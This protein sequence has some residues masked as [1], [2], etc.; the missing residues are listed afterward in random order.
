MIEV[1]PDNFEQLLDDG[2]L[3]AAMTSGKWSKMRRNGKTKTTKDGKYVPFV[4]G[5][6]GY[7]RITSDK[8]NPDHYRHVDDI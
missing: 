8:L 7:G 5:F 4:V 6:R 3:Y 2:L 1:T